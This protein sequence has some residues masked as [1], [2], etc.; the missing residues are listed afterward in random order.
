MVKVVTT[1]KT[2]HATSD[3]KTNASPMRGR[4]ASRMRS[5]VEPGAR[6]TAKPPPMVVNPCPARLSSS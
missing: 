1:T 5:A 3:A 4:L 6:T 2:Q